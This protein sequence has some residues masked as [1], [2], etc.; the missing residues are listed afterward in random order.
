MR[1]S[2]CIILRKPK[3][4]VIFSPSMRCNLPEIAEDREVRRGTLVVERDGLL[5]ERLTAF[6]VLDAELARRRD[7]ALLALPHGGG[8]ELGGRL[9]VGGRDRAHD[10]ER[11]E[12]GGGA[13]AVST[14]YLSVSVASA[15][16]K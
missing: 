13:A 12:G 14:S 6:V 15:V 3:T 11:E 1:S 7:L 2:S 8:G 4:E 10:R 16:D 5:G 9:G